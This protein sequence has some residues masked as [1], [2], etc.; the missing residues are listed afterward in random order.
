MSL[1]AGVAESIVSDAVAVAVMPLASVTLTPNTK[2]PLV[3]GTPL[4]VP[5]ALISMPVG[6]APLLSIHVYGGVPPFA[7]RFSEYIVPTW[8]LDGSIGRIVSFAG[9]MVMV[10]GCPGAAPRESAT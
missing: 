3:D 8:P 6:R 10:S 2:R 4:I 7:F 5:L 9:V 1:A